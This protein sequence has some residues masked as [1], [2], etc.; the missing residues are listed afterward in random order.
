MSHIVQYVKGQEEFFLKNV[1]VAVAEVRADSSSQ[2][3]A[4]QDAQADAT[5]ALSDASDAQA[6]ATQALSDA[7]DA[8]ADASQAL[9]DA[10]TASGAAAVADAKAV[11]AQ[12]LIAAGYKLIR[13]NYSFAIQGGT[14]AAHNLKNDAAADLVL[15]DKA[16]IIHTF[17]DGR[18]VCNSAADGAS[19]TIGVVSADDV[20]AVTVEASVVGLIDG[21][22]DNTMSNAIK[23]AAPV[24]PTMTISGE[25][26]TS[27]IFDVY[28]GYIIG[29]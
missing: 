6:D 5:Q 8:Q 9:S 4:I 16:I 13:G 24:T 23:L 10:S 28:F 26:L 1:E 22:Q 29:L 15:P 27:G 11:V 17:I 20:L 2:L 7:S 3:S 25:A 12:G 18:T 21:I 19:V 14:A